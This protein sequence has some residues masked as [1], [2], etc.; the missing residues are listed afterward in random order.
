MSYP[1]DTNMTEPGP[2]LPYKHDY[3]MTRLLNVS[4]RILSER[5]M[6]S[7]F[8][9]AIR[10]GD[11]GFSSTGTTLD[12]IF[13]LKCRVLT[14][15]YRVPKVGELQGHMAKGIAWQ[16]SLQWCR[17]VAMMV[18]RQARKG[19]CNQ[20]RLAVTM[21][22]CYCW[23]QRDLSQK[24][25]LKTAAPVCRSPARLRGHQRKHSRESA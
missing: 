10:G 25:R 24:S 15:A 2:S 4:V 19:L 11:E 13:H 20:F 23:L 21:A 8:V 1:T 5:G 16:K 18:G 14:L 3:I 7:M 12:S 9:D 17:P 6:Q 22:C